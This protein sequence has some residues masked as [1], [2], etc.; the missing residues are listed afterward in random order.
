MIVPD[1]KL[2]R[3]TCTAARMTSRYLSQMYDRALAP[4][5]LRTSQFALLRTLS[6][7]GAVGVQ[8][9]GDSMRLDRTTVGRTVRPLEREGLVRIAVDPG[10]RRGRLLEITEKGRERVL[11]AERLW[12]G[13]QARLE[14]NFGAEQTSALHQ[15]LASMLALDLS[16]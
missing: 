13:A 3:C 15:S 10:D 5:G 7:I 14:T 9:L 4:S 2:S 8:Q 16:A 11:A 6:G 12:A 1:K